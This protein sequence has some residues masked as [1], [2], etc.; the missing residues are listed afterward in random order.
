MI[1]SHDFKFIFLKSRKTGGSSFELALAKFLGN[2]D[3]VTPL[4]FGEELERARLGYLAP[5]NHVAQ[6]HQDP[7]RVLA[8]RVRGRQTLRFWNHTTALQASRRLPR[9]VWENYTKFTLVRNPYELVISRFYWQKRKPGF[10]N[11][12]FRTWLM[13]RPKILYSN[14]KMSHIGGHYVLDAF[15]RLED[16]KKG[17]EKNLV[18]IDLPEGIGEAFVK[19]SS[20]SQVR[21]AAATVEKI[22]RDFSKGLEI[23]NEI[24]EQDFALYGYKRLDYV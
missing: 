1:V 10:E 7:L 2:E 18:S 24:F 11:I 23:V 5:Q 3:I 12:E 20:K 4:S 17:F 6:F 14:R 21:P 15:L 8:N 19:I 16:I 22:F 9:Q 13:S